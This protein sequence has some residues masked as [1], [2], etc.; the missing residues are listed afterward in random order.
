VLAENTGCK[1]IAKNSPSVHH[2]TTCWAISSQLK[3][4]STIRKNVKQQYLLHMSSLC[5]ELRPLT[6]DIHSGVWGTQQISTGFASCLRYCSDVAH[7]RPTKLPSP[8]LVHY[9]YIFGG[10][11]PLTEFC[12]LQNSLWVQVLCSPILSALL[13]GT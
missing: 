12:Q 3:Y 13:H 6:A 8:G 11:C 1:N 9:V 7:R 2:C 5:A 4:I 10:S